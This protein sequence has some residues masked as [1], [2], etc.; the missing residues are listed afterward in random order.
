M[1]NLTFTSCQAINTI[2]VGQAITNY[3]QAALSIPIWFENEIPW[4]A[5]YTLLDAGK[6]EMGWICGWPYVQSADQED[7]PF[8]LLAAPVMANGR[9]QNRPV[10]FSDI[11]VHQ[12]SPFFRFSDLRGASWAYN[13]LNSFSGYLV[14][15]HHLAKMGQTAVYFK[16]AIQSGAHATSLQMILNQE[17]DSAAIDSTVLD[18]MLHHH[19]E[20]NAQIRIIERVGPSPIPPLVISKSVPQP[21]RQQIRHLLTH[22][23]KNENGRQRLTIGHLNKFV[24][25]TDTAYDGIRQM[26][27]HNLT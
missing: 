3:L 24:T 23:H 16:T 8:E 19:P 22:M 4:Q 20:L 5:R 17:V 18:W 21:I 14:M 7:P 25:V 15:Q 6:I 26:A 12:D 27:Q 10:Y 9:Y 11:V 13:G 1:N 2:A